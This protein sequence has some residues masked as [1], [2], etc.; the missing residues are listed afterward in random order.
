MQGRKT[1]SDERELHFSLSAHVPAHNFYRRLKDRLDLSFLYELTQPYYGRCGQQSIDPVVFF[2][3][4]LV[5]YLENMPTTLTRKTTSACRS[6]SIS[7]LPGCSTW[8]LPAPRCWQ[9]P[10]TPRARTTRFQSNRPSQLTSRPT[11]PTKG[12]YLSQRRGL[13]ALSLGQEGHLPQDQNRS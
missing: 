13:L 4:C 3:L 9:T 11:A 6:Y 2:K 7:F 10:A 1:F 8:A 12:L 5:G